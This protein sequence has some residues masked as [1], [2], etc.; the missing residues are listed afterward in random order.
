MR[1][2]LERRGEATVYFISD[3]LAKVTLADYVD[4][5]RGIGFPLGAK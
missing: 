4:V 2:R 1:T 5:L 3:A